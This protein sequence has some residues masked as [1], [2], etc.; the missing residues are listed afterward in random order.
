MRGCLYSFHSQ[1]Y[2]VDSRSGGL[3]NINTRKQMEKESGMKLP[4]LDMIKVAC[5]LLKESAT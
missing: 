2:W 5:Q 4:L 1:M 3:E